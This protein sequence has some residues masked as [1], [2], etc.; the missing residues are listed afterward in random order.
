[1]GPILFVYSTTDGHT[2]RISERLQAV[3]EAQGVAT[4]LRHLPEC[5]DADVADSSAI[6]IGASI[7][8]GKHK[9]E[10][11]AFIGRHQ[12]VL[13]ARPSALFS[14]NVVARKPEKNTPETNPY[15]QKFLRTITWKP[16]LMA[17]FAG[18]LNYPRLGLVDRTMIR[19]IM[20]MTK[21]PTDPTA[22]VE[23]TDWNR[24]EAFGQE[25]ARLPG[26]GSGV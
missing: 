5:S 21:G 11:A 15:L 4:R 16:R 18:Y 20:W 6:V 23:F 2:R 14:V 12:S 13:E 25:I 24:V 8:Y 7:R 9:P 1:M 17:V 26:A 19:F 22:V 10:V 3:V